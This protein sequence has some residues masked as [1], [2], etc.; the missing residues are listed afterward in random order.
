MKASDT[1]AAIAALSAV[2]NARHLIRSALEPTRNF[3]LP[4]DGVSPRPTEA[5]IEFFRRADK[6]TTLWAPDNTCGYISGLRGAAYTCNGDYQCAFEIESS[7]GNVGCC[8]AGVCNMRYSCID[9]KSYSS[10]SACDNSCRV[11][12]NIL[13]C[14]ATSAPY[15]NT[16]SFSGGI[17][18]YWCN[19]VDIST[20]QRASTTHSGG[21]DREYTTAD[22][23]TPVA[24][25]QPTV[26]VHASE[27]ASSSAS[28]ND[29]DNGGGDGQSPGLGS[30]SDLRAKQ[31]V[32]A[33]VGSA[34][35]AVILVGT[36]VLFGCCLAP[37]P[38]A[39]PE[40]EKEEEETRQKTSSQLVV[41]QGLLGDDRVDSQKWYW[42]TP[43]MQP[44]GTPVPNYYSPGEASSAYQQPICAYTGP[45]YN[46][47]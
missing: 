17:T 18:D 36:S 24:T 9:Y 27:S 40:D 29:D 23:T 46:Q 39:P 4:D 1:Y 10:S 33:A 26:T 6:L 32:Q 25:G 31:R 37:G 45:Q 14:T 22:E 43:S 30:E 38:E 42:N 41:S 3:Q 34:V 5:V 35:F 13:K 44:A 15:C 47:Y 28:S 7:T 2:A 20:A 16:I 11:D 8:S 19:N 21:D 12:A